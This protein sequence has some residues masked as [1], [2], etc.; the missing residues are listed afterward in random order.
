MILR[1]IHNIQLVGWLLI[2]SMI[3]SCNTNNKS[4]GKDTWN[5]GTITIATDENLKEITEQLV[6]IYEHDYENAKIILDFQPQDKIIQDFLNGDI[7]SMIVNR[8]LSNKEIKLSNQNQKA[9]I[10]ENIL[11]FNAIALIVN[12]KFKDTILTISDLKNYLLPNAAVKLVFGN[13]KSG[14]PKHILQKGN[15]DISLFKNALLVNNTSDVIEY[16]KRND[17]SIGFIPFNYISDSHTSSAKDILSKV[18]TLRIQDNNI[19]SSVSQE[20]IY[21]NSYPLLQQITIVL[22]NNPEIVG[23]AFVNWLCKERAAK[24]LLKAGLVPR[25]MP[26]RNIIVQDE[27][28]TN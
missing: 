15:L 6:Q 8:V 12:K 10:V 28:K 14:I 23:T 13:N 18:K 7:K 22:G 24:I 19:I 9:K 26:K 17:A 1:Y 27:I 25:F 21:N 2:I 16:V 11:A 20:S 5:T 4:A 3:L